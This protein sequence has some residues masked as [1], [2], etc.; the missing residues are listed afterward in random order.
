MRFFN[1]Y[2]RQLEEFTPRDPASRN[3]AIYTCGPMVYSRA[4]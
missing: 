4:H 3:T 2:S 1:A